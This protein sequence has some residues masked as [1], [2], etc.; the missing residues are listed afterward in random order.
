[1]PDFSTS[2]E[3]DILQTLSK[4]MKSNEPAKEPLLPESQLGLNSS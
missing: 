4:E 2:P 1:M 3:I